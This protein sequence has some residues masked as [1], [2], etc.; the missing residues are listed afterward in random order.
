MHLIII[1]ILL[2]PTTER[3]IVVGINYESLFSDGNFV[4]I[5]KL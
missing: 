1:I 4:T 2:Y 3:D 5:A